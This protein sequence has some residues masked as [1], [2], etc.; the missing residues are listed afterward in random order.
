MLNHCAFG[1]S[2]PRGSFPIYIKVKCVEREFEYIHR[3]TQACVASRSL[4]ASIIRKEKE[5]EVRELAWD[6]Q[7]EEI[8]T[9]GNTNDYL[10]GQRSTRVKSQTEKT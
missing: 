1:I 5:E 8:T 2:S 7:R 4:P 3:A 10:T 6:R 9:T